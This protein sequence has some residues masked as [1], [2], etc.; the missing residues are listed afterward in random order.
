MRGTPSK[1]PP[2]PRGLRHSDQEDTHPR[3]RPHPGLWLPPPAGQQNL[4]V[5]TPSRT[6]TCQPYRN[7]TAAFF[8]HKT[9][10]CTQ[11]NAH[12]APVSP[13]LN[14]QVKTLLDSHRDFQ[15]C[16]NTSSPKRAHVSSFPLP[17]LPR[18]ALKTEAWLFLQGLPKISVTPLL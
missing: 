2:S 16:Q 3:P 9:E 12:R 18:P 11:P 8:Q 6:P 5:L 4:P 14:E 17:L 15:L 13:S 7:K 10:P 1:G